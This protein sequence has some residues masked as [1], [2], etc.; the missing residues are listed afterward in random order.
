MS[1]V[2]QDRLQCSRHITVVP[3]IKDLSMLRLSTILILHSSETKPL[4]LAKM[5]NLLFYKYNGFPFILFF[6]F[7]FS[8]YDE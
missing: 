3:V 7:S 8:I 4:T 6:F 2:S 5:N 1:V